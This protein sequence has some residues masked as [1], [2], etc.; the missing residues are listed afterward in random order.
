M[1]LCIYSNGII[2]EF[3]PIDNSFSDNELTKSFENYP[4]IRTHRLPEIPNCWCIWG[5]MENPPDQEF[6]KLASEMVDADVY[7]HI[8][9]VHDSEINPDWNITDHIIYRSYK[10]FMASIG[11]FI[12]EMM[13]HIETENRQ[14][15]EESEELKGT[16]LNH[17]SEKKII[18]KVKS[19]YK[20]IKKILKKY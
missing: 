12:N 7:S 11:T 8:I 1:G 18:F 2:E 20:N 19:S 6:N 3:L 16:E 13:T 9:F 14:E 4:E 10:E 5:Q 15:L 17:L